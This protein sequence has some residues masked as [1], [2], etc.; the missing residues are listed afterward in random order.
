MAGRMPGLQLI[1]NRARSIAIKKATLGILT[2][3]D[4]KHPISARFAKDFSGLYH[5]RKPITYSA[6][7]AAKIAAVIP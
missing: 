6:T 2:T 3:Y 4:L 5:W 1:T 7:I